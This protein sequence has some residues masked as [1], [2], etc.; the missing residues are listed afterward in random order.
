M[1][2]IYLLYVGKE[3]TFKRGYLLI[4]Y[5]LDSFLVLALISDNVKLKQGKRLKNLIVQSK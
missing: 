4:K 5:F 3:R 2:V 1:Y